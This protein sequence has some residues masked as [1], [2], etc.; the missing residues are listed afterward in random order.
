MGLGMFGDRISKQLGSPLTTLTLHSTTLRRSDSP[1]LPR[2][3]QKKPPRSL[4]VCRFHS[5]RKFEVCFLSSPSR[6]HGFPIHTSTCELT[7]PLRSLR[8]MEPADR[9]LPSCSASLSISCF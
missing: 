5:F 2:S 3:Y 6:S 7:L 8:P 9:G 4:N 1:P